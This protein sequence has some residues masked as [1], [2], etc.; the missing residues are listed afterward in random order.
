MIFVDLDQEDPRYW[1][2]I[3]CEIWRR[4]AIYQGIPLSAWQ[5]EGV[6]FDM[7]PCLVGRGPWKREEVMV[8]LQEALRRAVRHEASI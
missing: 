5:I 3:G 4:G 1:A 8:V 6:M 7:R 2:Q